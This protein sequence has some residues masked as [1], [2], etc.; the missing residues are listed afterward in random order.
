MEECRSI[1]RFDLELPMVIKGKDAMDNSFEVETH[2]QNISSKGVYFLT[3]KSVRLDSTL[4]LTLYLPSNATIQANTVQEIK[5]NKVDI[6]GTVVRI[7][8]NNKNSR[9]ESGVAM[10]FD[11][12]SNWGS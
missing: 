3:K 5:R 6:E 12:K 11:H 10:R 8:K 2:S 9:K 1:K 7:E 4:Q